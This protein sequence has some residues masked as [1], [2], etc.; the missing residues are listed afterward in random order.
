VAAKP[1]PET[2][3]IVPTEEE[4]AAW[5]EQPVT[6]FVAQAFALGAEI[7]RQAWLAASWANGEADPLKLMELRTRA[8]AYRAFLETT[9]ADYL[10]TVNPEAWSKY[11]DEQHRSLGFVGIQ[12]RGL[13]P[14][15]SRP[16]AADQLRVNR[17]R[18]S[19]A[20][21]AAG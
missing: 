2:R 6:R 15:A 8:D 5:A 20:S 13:R 12:G 21:A 4:F 3:P 7:Q 19:G 10:K 9:W 17:R 11:Q 16:P 18:R 14:S 1:Q